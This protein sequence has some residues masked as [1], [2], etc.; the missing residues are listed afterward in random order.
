MKQLGSEK[1]R[2]NENLKSLEGINQEL[3]SIF[4]N[5]SSDPDTIAVYAHELGYIRDQERLIKLADFTGGID[6]NYS[7]GQA[8]KTVQPSYLSEW[9]CKTIGLLSGLLAFILI[10]HFSPERYHDSIKRKAHLGEYYGG[11]SS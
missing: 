3:D 11:F 8:L 10:S 9:I 6:R 7:P 1:E 5:L 2:V 4:R